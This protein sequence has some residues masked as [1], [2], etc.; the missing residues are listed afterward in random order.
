MA[1][2]RKHNSAYLPQSSAAG[3]TPATAE[4]GLPS[5]GIRTGRPPRAGSSFL[6]RF[7][8]LI[9][10]HGIA[11]IPSALFQYQG[12]LGLTAQEVWFISA[13]LSRK[14]TEDLPHPNLSKME[15]DTGV[16]E[17]RLR[18]YKQ[19]LC[20][21]GFLNVYPRYD[22]SGR[23]DSNYYDFGPL[24]EQI[25]NL[26]AGEP[27]A[28]NPIR[29][30]EGEEPEDSGLAIVRSAA[31][32]LPDHSFVARFGSVIVS[33]GVAAVPQALF[34]F[35][36]DLG[37]TP[38]QMWFI[39]YILSV[40]WAP[41]FPY[42]S[43]LKMATR[44]G[45]S[46]MQ[47][48]EIKNSLVTAGLLRLVRRTKED[49]GQDS[50]GYDF[51][52]LFEVLRKRLQGDSS[53]PNPPGIIT[54]LP[55]VAEEE[56]P[57]EPIKKA[58]PARQGRAGA[59]KRAEITRTEP[60]SE[61]VNKFTGVPVNRLTGV[62]VTELTRVADIE[63]TGVPVNKL[64]GET[65]T[66]HT[67]P[68]N[69]PSSTSMS[70]GLRGRRSQGVHNKETSIT[71]E[72]QKI[73]DSNQNSLIEIASELR[74]I[75]IPQVERF[76]PYIA[77]IITDFSDELS[78]QGHTVSNVTQALKIYRESGMSESSFADLLFEARK[79]VRSYQGRQGIG[80]INNKMAYYF[81]VL[82]DLVRG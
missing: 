19:R 57:T 77:A 34:S 78:D 39:L 64:T 67:E 52:P 25:E 45:Y 22:E 27:A 70:T 20:E 42:P 81:K 15:R 24:F 10:S 4:S 6:A 30:E 74:P 66:Q 28:H 21:G 5:K 75:T 69:P 61:A 18:R 16:P 26:I 65:V 11:T 36:G 9:V 35:E 71:E 56:T 7:G 72:Q 12:T 31:D 59:Q 51:A 55:E 14:W 1:D 50:N 60:V 37:L 68:V 54:V 13:V 76:S 63:I 23:Q 82:R 46:K 32:S 8:Q 80:T 48:H 33:R 29:A 79:L 17:R 38:Q 40:P 2:S 43:L 53:G 3:N 62:G 41:P 47:L 58:R 44:T 49:G 73:I